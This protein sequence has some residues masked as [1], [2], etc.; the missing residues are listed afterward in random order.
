MSET[1]TNIESRKPA[2]KRRKWPWITL[3]ITI[4]VILFLRWSLQAD[5]VFSIIKNQ[6]EQ[7]V[8]ETTGADFRIGEL[9]GDLLRGITVRDVSLTTDEPIITL[10]SLDVSYRLSALFSRTID[11]TELRISGLHASLEQFPDSSWNVMQLAGEAAEPDDPETE[12]PFTLELRSFIL[13]NSSIDVFAP[14][15]LPDD[16]LSVRD[17]EAGASLSY[18][19][20]MLDARLNSFS[21][22]LIE[23]RLPEG[24]RLETSGAMAGERITLDKLMISTGRSLLEAEALYNLAGN[25]I[26]ATID[27]PEISRR[28]MA[29]YL[30]DLP[31]FELAS[32]RMK[33]DGSLRDLQAA[34]SLHAPGL[35]RVELNTTVKVEP[36]IVLTALQIELNELDLRRLSGNPELDAE[37]GRI[38]LN[39]NGSIP[40]Q[41]YDEARADITLKL[42]GARFEEIVLSSLTLNSNIENGSITAESRLIFPDQRIDLKASLSDI[43]SDVPEWD[44]SGELTDI[45]PAFFAQ[46][47]SLTGNLNG[48]FTTIGSGFEPGT[49]PWEYRI[50]L[51]NLVFNEFDQL[52]D[53]TL[54]GTLDAEELITKIELDSPGGTLRADGTIADWQSE[55]PRWVFTFETSELDISVLA[56]LEEFPT[57]INATAA[58]EGEGTGQENLKLSLKTTLE[59]SRVLNEPFDQLDAHIDIENNILFIRETTIDSRFFS[60]FLEG[61]QN[62]NDL[63][64]TSNRLD[65]DFAISNLETFIELARADTLHGIGRI[66]GKLRPNDDGVPY[67]ESELDFTDM[68]FNDIGIE[69]ISG[70]LSALL[71]D[72]PE[73]DVDVLLQNPSSGELMLQDIRFINQTKIAEDAITG[74]LDIRIIRTSSF[75]LFHEGR[76]SIA[77]EIELQTS[78]LDIVEDGF[79]LN[80]ERDFG[81]YISREQEEQT[82]RMDTL[83]MASEN[84]ARLQIIAESGPADFLKAWIKADRLDLGATQEALLDE[85]VANLLFT[86][87]ISL[88]MQGN[89]LLA[90]IDT[91]LTKISFNG[92]NF[93][94]FMIR[95]QIAE[96]RMEIVSKLTHGET[97]LM[98]AAFSL[99][100]RLGDIEDFPDSFYEEQVEG[101]LTLN[102]LE[103]VNYEKFLKWAGLEALAGTISFESELS[104][105]A[106]NPELNG[107]FQFDDGSISGVDVEL[108]FFEFNYLNER[109]EIELNSELRSLGQTAATFKGTLPLFIDMRTLTVEEPSESEGINIKAV[110]NDFDISAFNDFLDRDIA[111]NL[112]GSLN[113]DI[114]ITG[115]VGNPDPTGNIRLDG[116]RIQIVENNINI[117][118]IAAD[119]DFNQDEVNINRIS[120]ESSGSF[121]L[122]GKILLDD[123][124]PDEFDINTRMRNFRV[125]N[126]RDLDAY[127]TM[128]TTIVGTLDEPRLSGE[129]IVERGHIYLD[130]FG[131]RRVEQ[132]TLEE[133]DDTLGTFFEDFF[134]ALAIEL[135]L[136]VSRRYFIRNRSNPELDLELEGNLD[137]VKSAG[138]ELELFGDITTVRGTANTLGRR[139]ELDEG[140]IVFSGPADNPEFDIQLSYRVRREDDIRIMYRIT[141]TAEEPEFT[142]DSEPEMELQDIISYTLFGRPFHALQGWEQGVSGNAS[143]GDV[144]ADAALELLLDRLQNIAADRLGVD[145]IEIDNASQTDGGTRIK[146]G[147]FLSD[148]LFVALVQELGSDPNSQ[149]IIEY[150][151]RRNLELIFTGSDDFRSGLDIHWRLDY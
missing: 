31:E 81:L 138:N 102:P 68:L 76:F 143:A 52:G 41:R 16:R 54:D 51:N 74:D 38:T 42:N 150:L 23:G 96:N 114:S 15:L 75:G 99:P 37:A 106:G 128:N 13:E 25:K 33:A 133:E 117:T 35:L 108:F 119:I 26:D 5:W 61:R 107:R 43:W 59:N 82:V 92:L 149:V 127:I 48:A 1:S 65:F 145:V 109:S 113:A 55:L 56:N 137:V 122:S 100:F 94:R 73:I 21:L 29:A 71:L 39:V 3:G 22:Q 118:S 44:I 90:D 129:V 30:D 32:L 18:S 66:S 144:V 70:K 95:T 116:G 58:L 123:F 11:V 57:F 64:D 9:K 7:I 72:E 87:E 121:T 147:K 46:D 130:N 146:A 80:L 91:E 142:F 24:I 88:E 89:E 105:V 2:K 63:T 85:R 78:R 28:D 86:G 136:I 97:A 69:T 40:V 132:V 47:S 93:D 27:M 151:L 112:R 6:A 140:V 49:T 67:F 83:S 10:D 19:S 111:R 126:T 135:N 141:G 53:L 125:F 34:L 139:F 101:Y 14:F 36:E 103:L 60:G 50:N 134:D 45:N 98:D 77:D 62:L 131:E 8:S 124:I 104:G 110:T 17:I 4:F 148:R 115:T 12:F 79:S 20:E 84:G 120:A